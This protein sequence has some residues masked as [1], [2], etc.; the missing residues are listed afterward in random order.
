MIADVLVDT[1][2]HVSLVWNGL[3]PDTCLK[4]SDRPV[5]LGVTTGGIMAGGAREAER[6]L[7]FWEHDRLDRRDQAKRLMLHGKFCQ[8]DLSDWDI[9][10]GYDFMVSNSAGALPHCA[11]LIREANERLS[12]LSTHYVPGGSQ[13]TGDEEEKI[14]R[15]VKAAGIKSKDGDEE[16]LQ[17]YG[18]FRDGYCRMMEGLGMDTP[19]TGVSASKEAPK[20]Q[21][22]ARYWH[23]GDSAWNKHWDAEKWG[24]LY[25]H[26]SQ[27]DSERI[28]NKIIADRAK[29][30][31]V[32]TG[33]GSG[34]A[35][36]EVLRSK[37]DSIA[38][39]EFVFAPDEETF[40][41]ATG[42]SLPSPGQA[43]STHAYFV[44]GAQ[45]HPTGDEALIHRVQ[46]V[47]MR[48][49]FEESNDPKV[50]VQTLSFD[51]IDRV[52]HYMKDGMHDRVAA[53]QARSRVKSPHWWDDQNLITGKFTKDEF[54]AR[55]MDHMADQEEP[56]GSNSPTWKFPRSGIGSKLETPFNIQ[57][58]RKLSAGLQTHDV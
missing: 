26:G 30:V 6:G 20:L 2:A 10:M 36:G 45:C 14:V 42:T 27:R 13:W 46:A 55:V 31:L 22:C 7:D 15:A 8:T 51:K 44:D 5:R 4:S 47:P 12:W 54:L 24:H 41:D 34:D 23:K 58:F 9:I 3:F 39:N 1:G 38:L 21:K 32:L 52:V 50:E 48:V 17:E 18:L 56:V 11:K 43:W 49:N 19:S 29:G 57:E 33:L 40:L 16:H 25:V 53:K 28:V 37:I 35:L